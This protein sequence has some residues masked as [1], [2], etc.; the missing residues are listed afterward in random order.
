LYVT[1]QKFDTKQTLSFGGTPI[2]GS[3]VN[4]LSVTQQLASTEQPYGYN[5][6]FEVC[7]G[8][9][10]IRAPVVVVTSDIES[11]SVKMAD[12]VIPNSCQLGTGKL[13]SENK[14][15]ITVSLA[16]SGDATK[17]I[18][19]LE[20]RIVEL[21][22]SIAKDKQALEELTK[23][24]QKPM[25][26]EQKVSELTNSIISNRDEINNTRA[27]LHSLLYKFYGTQVISMN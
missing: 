7:A 10:I 9:Q 15:S 4:K 22:A 3:I 1:P 13:K 2:E 16:N 27:L 26:Y 17:V 12:R 25:D 14:D 11:T 8:P 23:M 6:V 19:E 21:Q 18:T 24:A 20:N 5:V